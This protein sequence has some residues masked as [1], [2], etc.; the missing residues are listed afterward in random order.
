MTNRLSHDK[1]NFFSKHHLA[2]FSLVFVIATFVIALIALIVPYWHDNFAIEDSGLTYKNYPL[3]FQIS[4]S[5]LDWSF[6]KDVK[7]ESTKQGIVFDETLR[8]GIFIVSPAKHKVSVL[9]FDGNDPT[10]LDLSKFSHD[11]IDEWKKFMNVT[12]QISTVTSD[13]NSAFLQIIGN[14]N[15]SHIFFKEKI[16]KHNGKIYRIQ[17]FAK[18]SQ[19]LDDETLRTLGN[20]Y[21]SFGYLK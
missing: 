5:S 6:I 21:E 18:S 3:A 4:R 2:K 20:T 17:V 10:F 19:S 9:V 16:E 15:S 12:S 1:Y 11:K 13:K 14:Y 7:T 8:G